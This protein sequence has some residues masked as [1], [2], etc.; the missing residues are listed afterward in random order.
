MGKLTGARQM[1]KLG[2]MIVKEID[3]K[4]IGFALFVFPFK[5]PGISNYISNGSRKDMIE[6]LKEKIRRFE[7]NEDIRTPK[8][9]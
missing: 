2:D 3:N 4:D 1:Q 5:A 7:N 6:A 9:N 8:E